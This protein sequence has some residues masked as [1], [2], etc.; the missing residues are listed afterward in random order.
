[1]SAVTER[2]ATAE[3]S[4]TEVHFRHPDGPMIHI[5]PEQTD[6]ILD[7]VN[8]ILDVLSTAGDGDTV[9]VA[10]SRTAGMLYPV[11]IKESERRNIDLNRFTWGHIDNYL[12]PPESD[13]GGPEGED[14]AAWVRINLIEP[15]GIS[16]D[17][18]FPL[19]GRTEDP[20]KSARMYDEWLSSCRIAA[21][22]AGA[23][24]PEPVVHVA[25][26]NPDMDTECG[27]CVIPLSPETVERNRERAEAAGKNP[28]PETAITLGFKHMRRAEHIFS[29][30]LGDEYAGR[31][32]MALVDPVSP[33]VI[34]SQWRTD[35]FREKVEIYLDRAAGAEIVAAFLRKKPGSD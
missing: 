34:A 15:A 9:L 1:M 12:Y 6:T 33:G 8:G 7:C 17:R 23:P 31:M 11:L 16:P 13:A 19:S 29:V 35:G 14:F 24:G 27:V 25:F 26:M 30:A 21:V 22:I 32:K 5:I 10:A 18:F 20:Q 4:S 3:Y 2:H 28:P